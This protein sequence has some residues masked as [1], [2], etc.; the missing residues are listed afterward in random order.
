MGLLDR[1]RG[2]R[3]ALPAEPPRG[4]YAAMSAE[5]RRAWEM[6]TSASP[7]AD[8]AI[9]KQLMERAVMAQ[10][11]ALSVGV[12]D[13]G[14]KG[15]RQQ[16]FQR[17]NLVDLYAIAHNNNVVKTATGVLKQEVFRRGFRWDPAFVYRHRQTG[18]EYT[19]ED[20][21]VMEERA[22]QEIKSQ[23]IRPDMGQRQHFEEIMQSANIYD[24]SLLTLLQVLEDDLNIAD[25]AFLL[26]SSD[27]QWN[28]YRPE[29]PPTRYVRQ[30]FRLDPVFMEF[31]VDAEN[32]PGFAH[33][34]CLLHRDQLLDIPRDEDWQVEWKGRCPIDG[35]VTYPVIYRYSPFKGTF[36]LTSGVQGPNAQS[37][38]LVKGEVIHASKYSPSELYGYS[39]I[40][41]I[42][43][44]ALS[45]IGMDRYLYDY[46]FER[47]MPQGVVTTVTDN[48]QDLESR[49]D[50]MLAETLNNPHY[51]PWLA[52]SSKTGQG[53]TEFVRFAYSLDELQFL[54]VQEYI[55]RSVSTLYGVPG[56]FMGREEGVGGL[57]NESQ[58]LTRMS[59]GARLSQD[60]FNVQI[61]PKI[62]AAFGVTDWLLSLESAE[63]QSEEFKLDMKQRNAQW[64]A[65]MV[66]MGFGL[67]YDQDA[68][69]FT[70]NGEVKSREEQEQAQ[71]AMYGGGM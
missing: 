40:L 9:A 36:G 61:L 28:L 62:L 19:D 44:K 42:Y 65:T 23:L 64:A 13:I 34:V 7:S 25:D 50:Q 43:E 21:R 12:P 57:N 22:R 47:Q 37:I 52:V 8:T 53:R 54:P 1:I 71:A 6:L 55:E 45:L 2:N 60:V 3:Q 66:Q 49:K 35:F 17:F 16:L 38:Y 4:S 29:M 11:G 56:L 70:I 48:P 27:Y 41:S 69:H 68:D 46:F 26:L 59:R 14:F 51:I 30:I 33:H 24:Q 63:E 20:L 32:R 18:M 39:P 10:S 58:Q 15:V 67:R 5:G 31:D